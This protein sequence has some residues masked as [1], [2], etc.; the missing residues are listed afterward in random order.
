[1]PP[2]YAPPDPVDALPPPPPGPSTGS[3]G[4]PEKKASGRS[5]TQLMVSLLPFGMGQF[6]NGDTLW[7]LVFLGAETGALAYWY[8]N[9][10]DAEAAVLAANEYKKQK[11]AQNPPNTPADEETLIYFEQTRVYAKEK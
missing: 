1:P 10:Q 9:R 5:A 2:I 11:E 3:D 7:G 8:M 6:Q 4:Q